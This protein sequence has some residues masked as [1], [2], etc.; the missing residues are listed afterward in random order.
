MNAQ[1]DAYVTA[2]LFDAKGIPMF[3]LGDGTVRLVTLEGFIT[4]QA[5][6]GAVLSACAHPSGQGM[7]TGGDD[8]KVVWTRAEGDEM[9]ATEIA[10]IKGRWID[11]VAASAES[12]LIA[13][14]AGRDL[15]VRDSKDAAFERTFTHDK[16]VA[17]VAFDPK[18]R[19]LAAATYG[20]AA[21][22]YAR[23]EKQQPQMLKWAGSHQLVLW[24]PDGKFLMSS[25]QE[26]SLHGWRMSD[27]KD[28]RM[29]G[30]PAK[31]KSLAFLS[32]GLMLATAGAN[33]AVIWPFQGANGPMG[34]EA[35]EIAYDQ[36]AMVV[37][38]AATPAGAVLAGGLD[39]GRVWACELK[40]GRREMLKA[41]KG[42]PI[43]G[44]AIT[45]DGRSVAWGDEDGGAG[46]LPS[47]L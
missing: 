12:G 3:A 17:D 31:V 42:P 46:V 25:M 15:H 23:I 22:W 21:L 16:S 20:G 2:A 13:F 44:L 40:S 47:G 8:G 18:G 35:A 39:D 45:P 9:A 14:T 10:K 11:A 32:G 27:S 36:D 19:R 34:K 41:E 28:M 29:G 6:D 24:S 30:Y 5:H 7:I 4:I 1:F 37:R 33:G 38:V 43:S 26:N